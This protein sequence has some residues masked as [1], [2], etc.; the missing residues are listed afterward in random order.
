MRSVRETSRIP[1]LDW[2]YGEEHSI[3]MGSTRVWELRSVA[4]R[5]V[6]AVNK[7]QKFTILATHAILDRSLLT[8]YSELISDRNTQCTT[9]S[10]DCNDENYRT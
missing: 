6:P 8:V 3:T 2:A 1:G 7:F 9:L 10:D 4:S 5:L